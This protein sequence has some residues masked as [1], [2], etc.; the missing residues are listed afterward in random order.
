MAGYV[1]MALSIGLSLSD[2]LLYAIDNQCR[3]A[4]LI[5]AVE[6]LN[7]YMHIPSESPAVIENSRPAP[8]WPHTGRVDIYDLQ[9][10]TLQ[11][12]LCPLREQMLKC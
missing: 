10:S 4:N 5:V 3:L 9:V 2:F 1:G 7:Q 8:A 11:L 12:C 6:R